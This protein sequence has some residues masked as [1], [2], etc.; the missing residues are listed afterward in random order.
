MMAGMS[1]KEQ[2]GFLRML[3]NSADMSVPD[4]EKF[5]LIADE[6]EGWLREAALCEEWIKG[7]QQDWQP[8][9]TAP[10]DG[11]VVLLWG[12]SPDFYSDEDFKDPG[13][14]KVRPVTAWFGKPEKE[15]YEAWPSC[16]RFCSFD[17]GIYG[18]YENPTHWAPC[19]APPVDI[20]TG[21]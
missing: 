4:Q 2:V 15:D 11:T 12:G 5:T 10:K 3:A 17:S 6:Y 16:W 7:H 21:G 18:E 14:D 19:P 8:I 1:T 9:E 13:Y 20:P